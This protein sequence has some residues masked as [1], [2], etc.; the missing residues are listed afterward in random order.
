MSVPT[1]AVLLA[2]RLQVLRTI[3]IAMV[4]SL[5]IYVGLGVAMPL[6]ILKKPVVSA[7]A[8]EL[9]HVLVILGAVAAGGVAIWWRRRSMTPEAL[10]AG[11]LTPDA[12]FARFQT[13]LIIGWAVT[14]V[15]GILGLASAM[16]TLDHRMPVLLGGA[17]VLLLLVHRP[18]VP[19]LE[20]AM[21]RVRL[22]AR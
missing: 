20:E 1:D 15:M 21:R 22:G 5:L 18:P 8:A 14:E 17:A 2:R 9:V 4:V 12:V 13:N 10:R 16:M 11:A 6:Y 19:A 7:G 3:W